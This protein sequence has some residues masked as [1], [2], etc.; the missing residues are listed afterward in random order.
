MIT[1]TNRPYSSDIDLAAMTELLL[2]G[3]NANIIPLW[4]TLIELRAELAEPPIAGGSEVQLWH[5]DGMLAGFVLVSWREDLLGVYTNMRERDGVVVEEMLHWVLECIQAEAARRGEMVRIRARSR[6][7]D[8]ALVTQLE[9]SGFERAQRVTIC[10]T[11]SLD[12]PIPT[13]Q[14]SAGFSIRS[15]QGEEEIEA[16]L[17]LHYD[18]FGEHFKSSGSRRAFMRDPAYIPDLDLVAV[19]ADGTLAALCVC[20]IDHEESERIGHTVGW[21]DPIGTRPQFRRRGLARDLILEGFRRL[22]AHG[23]AT[24]IL[25][26]GSDNVAA[27]SV[28]ESVGYRMDHTVLSYAKEVQP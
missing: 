6:E 1:L 14:L 13:S 8:V 15:V 12:A 21:T 22:K 10:M 4:P 25:A 3:R 19:A 17:A 9:R 27:R 23:V 24:A 5:R 2:A 7:A 26:T 28:Y 20:S 16:Y 11:R 18:A